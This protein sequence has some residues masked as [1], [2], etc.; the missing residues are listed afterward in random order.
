MRAI[1]AVQTC[2]DEKGRTQSEL[3]GAELPPVEV[4]KDRIVGFGFVLRTDLQLG[5][6]QGAKNSGDPIEVFLGEIPYFALLFVDVG[7][8]RIES[9]ARAVLLHFGERRDELLYTYEAFGRH[10]P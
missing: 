1:V 10:R 8:G 2:H 7:R 4:G 5:D 6:A 9:S 3:T